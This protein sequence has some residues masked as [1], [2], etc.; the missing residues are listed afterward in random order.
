LACSPCV[1]MLNH[2][3][4]P[5]HDAQCMKRITTD[6]VMTHVRFLLETHKP[7]PPS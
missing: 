1:N 7:N 3:F 2:R 4:S 5:C 6:V